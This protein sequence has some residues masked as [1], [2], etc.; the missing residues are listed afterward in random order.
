MVYD[1][2][3]NRLMGNLRYQHLFLNLICINPKP[4]N[5]HFI[6]QKVGQSFLGMRTGMAKSST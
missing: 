5:T 3:A 2:M 1:F 4:I 6:D